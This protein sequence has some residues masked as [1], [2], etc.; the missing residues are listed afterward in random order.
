MIPQHCMVFII[1]LVDDNHN[2]VIDSFMA[3]S[4]FLF[5]FVSFNVHLSVI[6]V[7]QCWC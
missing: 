1:V 5:V 2:D 6:P 4:L 3:M 7:F